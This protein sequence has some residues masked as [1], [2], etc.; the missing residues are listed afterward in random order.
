MSRGANKRHRVEDA[1][2]EPR[3]LGKAGQ[4]VRIT[5]DLEAAEVSVD[6]RD[7]CSGTRLADNELVDDG[8]AGITVIS[9]LQCRVQRAPNIWVSRSQGTAG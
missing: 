5:L 9:R 8:C 4:G 3:L 1:T 2:E 6:D 7:I